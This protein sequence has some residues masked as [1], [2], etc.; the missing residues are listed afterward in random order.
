MAQMYVTCC[1]F[2]RGVNSFTAVVC[3]VLKSVVFFGGGGGGGG[4]ERKS[5]SVEFVS[6]ECIASGDSIYRVCWVVILR[7]DGIQHCC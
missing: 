6:L 2:S 3:V 4:S 1:N 7:V 5:T